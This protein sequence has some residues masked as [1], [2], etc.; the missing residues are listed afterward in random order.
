MGLSS[1]EI[2]FTVARTCV[3][4]LPETVPH[5]VKVCGYPFTQRSLILDHAPLNHLY[6]RL[7]NLAD[8][9]QLRECCDKLLKSGTI[10]KVIDIDYSDTRRA[11][12]YNKHFGKDVGQTHDWKGTP[13]YSYIFSAEEAQA[14]YLV[15][16]DSDMLF[17]QQV[18]FNWVEH[19]IKL[20]QEHPDILAVS[21]LAGPPSEDGTLYQIDPYQYDLRGFNRFKT[22]SA[23]VFLIDRKRFDLL[24]PLRPRKSGDGKLMFWEQMVT[25]RMAETQF[26]R[27][28]LAT[29]QAWSL[30]PNLHDSDFITAL[31]KIRERVETGWY[32]PEQA[33]YYD[34]KLGAWMRHLGIDR[35][36]AKVYSVKQALESYVE[37]LRRH[38]T[39]AIFDDIQFNLRVS[40]DGGGQWV[41]DLSDLDNPITTGDRPT[42]CAISVSASDLIDIFNGDLNAD[43]ATKLR[44]VKMDGDSRIFKYFI[45]P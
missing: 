17:Y 30:H 15:H 25:Q 33:G 14:D 3:P 8:L 34:L 38:Q 31:P 18:G 5:L 4:Y 1:C 40:G 35:K 16:F 45:S 12:I 42:R 37:T 13:I 10:D 24:L 43:L 20:L 21:P 6:A 41:V 22:F 2:S 39:P 11:R 26:I 27:V 28:D 23:R 32:P 7:P 36:S 9:S 29:P 19:G 44:L